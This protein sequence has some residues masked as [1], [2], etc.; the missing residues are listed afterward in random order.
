MKYAFGLLLLM[1]FAVHPGLMAQQNSSGRPVVIQGKVVADAPVSFATVTL[2]R[3][4][5]SSEMTRTVTDSTGGFYLKVNTTDTCFLAVSH[6]GFL[7]AWSPVFSTDTAKEG[8][9]YFSIPLRQNASQLKVV[10]VTKMPVIER[11]LDRI[12]VR[13]DNNIVAAGESV[14][15]LLKTLPGIV[16]DGANNI[17][18]KGKSDIRLMI[19]GRETYMKDDQLKNLLA[20]MAANNI[21]KIE[22]ISNPPAKYAAEGAGGI[23]NLITKTRE[24]PG[25]SGNIYSSY[26]QGIYGRTTAGGLVNF[27]NKRLLLTGSYD[28][29]HGTG[30]FDD[31]ETRNFHAASPVITFHQLTH[32][33]TTS[34]NHYY[35]AGVDWG[36][37]PNQNITVSFDGSV[38]GMTR[39]YSATLQVYHDSHAIDSSFSIDNFTKS[40]YSNANLNADYTLRIDTLGQ[41]LAA[42]YSHLQYYANDTNSYHSL[43]FNNNGENPR[44]RQMD[45][46]YNKASISVDAYKLDYKRNLPGK[47]LLETGLK[48]TSSVTD[49]DIAFYTFQNGA[50]KTDTS[51][52]NH[53]IYT[54]N[55]G[56]AYI[57]ARKNFKKLDVQLG[58][59]YEDTRAKIDLITD[60]LI[61]R[62]HL[63]GLF[64]TLFLEYRINDNHKLNY[65]SGRRIKRPDYAALNPFAFYYD[66]FSYSTGN[67][68]LLP[69]YTF[70]NEFTYT[71]KEENSFSL[72]YS[73][74][75]NLLNEITIQNDTT[76]T[77]IYK[78]ENINSSRSLY[79]DAYVPWTIAPWWSTNTD[80]NVTYTSIKGNAAYGVFSN[81]RT[82]VSIS[83]NHIITFA[84]LYTAQV[85]ILYYG[86]TVYG[87]TVFKGRERISL[88]LKR[89]FFKK[90]LTATLRI[91][92]LFYT[93][94]VRTTTTTL[95]QDIALRTVRDTRRV[96]ITLTYNFRSGAKFNERKVQFGAQ[97]EKN[98]MSIT[99]KTN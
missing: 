10:E 65:T 12:I 8:V 79:L 17:Y 32:R 58:L 80:V 23:I 33:P 92:D 51:R 75:T 31:D 11:K 69:Q 63:Q 74:T 88:G 61:I 19:D 40:H 21:Q 25:V 54:E 44:P 91:N 43:F 82:E 87:V 27:K 97:D 62:R 6:V 57:S 36:F 50:Y 59:R 56:A 15:E 84:K 48:Y 71:Y 46:S 81:K 1:I 26:S 77:V 98:R 90:S 95:N 29:T 76:K 28:L 16:I 49:N 67:P 85:N 5:D 73:A 70:S 30:F 94:K 53:F 34:T 55:I 96:G 24:T 89:S 39:P 41:A 20:G 68:Y 52:T 3:A 35:K 72:G 86:P 2:L 64:P 22:I 83:N 9:M 14:M 66:P 78:N 60:T 37:A 93:D 18:I 13:V 45:G 47:V 4:R 99:P 42:N 38:S 7:P